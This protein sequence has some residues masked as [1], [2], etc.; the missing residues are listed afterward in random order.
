MIALQTVTSERVRNHTDFGRR[1]AAASHVL[2]DDFAAARNHGF[3]DGGCAILAS[4]LV[5]WSKD[6]L[7]LDSMVDGE[8]SDLVHHVVACD[9]EWNVLLDA[10]GL[11]A[12]REMSIKIAVMERMP[13]C[14]HLP[15]YDPRT[16]PGI[17]WDEEESAR[18]A[19]LLAGMLPD[20]SSLPWR[21][22]PSG[23][24][25]KVEEKAVMR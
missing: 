5:T 17:P 10:D 11:A 3:L 18:L 4:A 14:R 23:P 25:P 7:R 13:G 24:E 16:Q 9:E 15:G 1:L 20:P 8:D 22:F 6:R 12:P 21:G 19:V 2:L